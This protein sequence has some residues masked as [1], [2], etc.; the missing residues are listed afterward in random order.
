MASDRTKH[1]ICVFALALLPG[2]L[3]S[4]AGEAQTRLERATEA[5]LEGR[6]AEA[7]DLLEAETAEVPGNSDAWLQLGL[8]RSAMGEFQSARTAF[9]TTLAIAPDYTDAELGLARLDWFEGNDS[10]ALQRLD[11]LQQTADVTALR[12]QIEAGQSQPP[13]DPW[14]LTLGAGRSGLS[15][16]L[17]DWTEISAALTRRTDGPAS[18]TL[19]VDYAERFDMS[20][21]YIEGRTDRRLND[22]VTGYLAAGGTP[23]AIF[24]PKWSVSGGLSAKLSNGSGSPD[25]LRVST[26][27]R[28]ADYAAGPVQSGKL[29]LAKPFADDT[30]LLGGS[31][32]LLSDEQGE[33]RRGY[34]LQGEWQA[35]AASRLFLTY[36]D[37]PETSDGITLDVKSTVLGWR[38]GLSDSVSFQANLVHETRSVYDRTGVYVAT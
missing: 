38:Q 14:R 19:L 8:A 28:F 34:A 18:Y 37:A 13:A 10:A 21:V 9:E 25:A 4:A 35:A 33:T 17:P 7:E 27:L 2:S 12:H 5:R 30:F 20:D 24:R 15:N 23:D 3:L 1:L 31:L 22:N 26:D 36:A 29:S 11:R 6:F 16:S 32:I